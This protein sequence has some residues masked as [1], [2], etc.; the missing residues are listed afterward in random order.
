MR[1][2]QGLYS[3]AER[4]TAPRTGR[5]H[6][7]RQGGGLGFSWCQMRKV[8][9]TPPQI[10]DM[11]PEAP[12]P[13]WASILLSLWS[14]RHD[15]WHTCG[16]PAPLQLSS[17]LTQVVGVALNVALLSE[18]DVTAAVKGSAFSGGRPHFCNYKKQGRCRDVPGDTWRYPF[19][20]STA[21]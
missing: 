2:L 1:R 18:A 3:E 13:P 4:T 21:I 19:K 8:K 14:P 15:L 12:S 6:N 9:G 5:W 16:I 11:P 20:L 7:P 10:L 17:A